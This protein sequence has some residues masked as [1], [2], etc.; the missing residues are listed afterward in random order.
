LG[1]AVVQA[2]NLASARWGAAGRWQRLA[3]ALPVVSAALVTA[4]GLWLCFD[5]FRGH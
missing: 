5:S 2:R 4:L 3:G 1:I